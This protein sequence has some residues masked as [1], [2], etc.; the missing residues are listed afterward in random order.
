[1]SQLPV[2]EIWYLIHSMNNT[3]TISVS[4]A[5]LFSRLSIDSKFWI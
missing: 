2:V 4:H 1:M 5:K 3:T